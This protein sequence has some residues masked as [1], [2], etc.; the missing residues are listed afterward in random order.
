VKKGL[1]DQ[2]K[3]RFEIFFSHP[4]IAAARPLVVHNSTSWHPGRVTFEYPVA[5]PDDH[6]GIGGQED[7]SKPNC[8]LIG[9]VGVALFTDELLIG[10]V[11]TKTDKPAYPL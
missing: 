11:N 4:K 10:G 1:Q 5:F 2:A 8:S 6:H 7:L 9:G 3:R